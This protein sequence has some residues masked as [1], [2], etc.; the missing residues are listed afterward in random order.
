MHHA[1]IELRLREGHT[2]IS[3]F[4]L[5]SF[6]IAPVLATRSEFTA[7]ERRG[8]EALKIVRGIIEAIVSGDVVCG[9]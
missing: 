6:F 8:R 2:Y 3:G 5:A 4:F 9:G 1:Q 7:A